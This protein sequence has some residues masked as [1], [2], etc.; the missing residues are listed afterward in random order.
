MPRDILLKRYPSFVTGGPLPPGDVPVFVFHSLEPE[1]FARKLD[2][3]A[4]NG[5]LTLSSAEY[6]E[7]LAGARPAPDR[8]VVL[9][10]DDGRG[11]LWTVGQP[12]LEQ[13]LVEAGAQQEHGVL[14]R[15]QALAAGLSGT[16]ALSVVEELVRTV[17]AIVV[18]AFDAEGYLLWLPEP[19]GPKPAS[20]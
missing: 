18:R 1:S 19:V 13:V 4:G 9:T 14:G 6:V 2:Y 11:S 12:L 5:Y 3:L 7:V 10:F 16:I 8:A 20:P 15:H 17:E